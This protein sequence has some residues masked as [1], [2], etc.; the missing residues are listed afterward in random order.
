MDPA[1]MRPIPDLRRLPT[2]IMAA[3]M[4]APPQWKV[5]SCERSPPHPVEGEVTIE[6]NMYFDYV[7]GVYSSFVVARDVTSS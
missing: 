1:V 6:E 2:S 3:V 7:F 4:D 5:W